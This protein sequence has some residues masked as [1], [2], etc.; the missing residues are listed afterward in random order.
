MTNTQQKVKSESFYKFNKSD[1]KLKWNKNIVRP[2][3]PDGVGVV[4]EPLQ[5]PE[6]S[7]AAGVEAQV[8][9]H[10]PGDQVWQLFLYLGIEI[11][12]KSHIK[13]KPITFKYK[14]EKEAG[15]NVNLVLKQYVAAP[16][17]TAARRPA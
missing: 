4:P 6:G 17:R 5:P 10:Q 1:K 11:P 15:M 8:L 3:V 2:D 7:V 14:T 16:T 13:K 12:V 9:H